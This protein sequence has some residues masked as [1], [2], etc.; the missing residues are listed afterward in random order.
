MQSTKCVNQMLK[1]IQ[2]PINADYQPSPNHFCSLCLNIVSRSEL[3]DEIATGH[4]PVS[5][6]T[7]RW[8]HHKDLA[9]LIE[10]AEYGCHLC[11]LLYA[12]SCS[13]LFDSPDLPPDQLFLRIEPKGLIYGF[14]LGL[15]SNADGDLTEHTL[16]PREGPTNLLIEE[17]I[18]LSLAS[19][20]E[21]ESTLDLARR[22]LCTCQ[23]QHIE[24]SEQGFFPLEGPKRLLM[25]SG[26]HSVPQVRL[27]E[28]IPGKVVSKYITLSHC[29]GKKPHLTLKRAN[30]ADFFQEVP[31]MN[32]PQTFQDAVKITVRL[33]Y[34]ALWIDALCIVQDDEGDILKEI[35]RM[36]VIY[37]N[38]V[39]TIAALSS[40]GCDGGCFARRM[41][42]ARIP[43]HF[44]TKSGKD[45]VLGSARIGAIL[46]QLD[47]K[48]TMG[49][50]FG[51]L[52]HTRGWVVQERALS[53]RTLYFSNIGIHWE[54]CV[55]TVFE[56][57]LWEGRPP[58]FSSFESGKLKMGISKI[59]RDYDEAARNTFTYQKYS[60]AYETGSWHD[61]WWHLVSLY[62]NC[63]LTMMSDR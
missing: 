18:T 12:Q 37:G 33:G 49:L 3:L 53:S 52:L 63:S 48:Q 54:C 55:M 16:S 62:T 13:T 45:F 26:T 11:S 59:L 22:W 27:V 43:C 41:P 61:Q 23:N 19:S 32:L 50:R 46:E 1:K 10:S 36:G 7:E 38:T 57:D 39:C 58:G 15:E 40:R 25:I 21:S 4:R 24:C 42:L 31:W 51:P 44:K 14:L 6:S 28:P 29:W 60:R 9:S 17:Q 5:C 2:V 56:T 30:Y 34:N 35:P 20:T 8:P 47:P